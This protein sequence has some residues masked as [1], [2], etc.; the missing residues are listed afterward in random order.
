M[1]VSLP[2]LG[3]KRPQLLASFRVTNAATLHLFAFIEW[4]R[5]LLSFTNNQLL[6]DQ[7]SLSSLVFSYLHGIGMIRDSCRR[8]L[9]QDV[10]WTQGWDMICTNLCHQKQVIH[11]Q[12]NKS[13]PHNFFFSPGKSTNEGKLHTKGHH[14]LL[15]KEG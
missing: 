8:N 12:G 5:L 15:S 7:I 6:L 9:G 13:C 4:H 11:Y 2:I 3:R 14:L 1:V 10:K